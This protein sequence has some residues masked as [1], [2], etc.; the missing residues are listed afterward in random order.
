[1]PAIE[2]RL[3]SVAVSLF[4]PNVV[5][6]IIKPSIASIGQ[7]ARSLVV[8]LGFV[9][10]LFAG[11]SA[12]SAYVDGVVKAHDQ[13]PLRHPLRQYL[14]ALLL[15]IVLL[16]IVIAVAPLVVLSSREVARS[17]P[18]GL[19]HF[20]RFGNYPVLALAL[21]LAVTTLYRA[22]LPRPLP[23]HRLIWGSALATGLFLIATCALRGYLAWKTSSGTNYG[24]L[25]TPIALMLYAFFAGFDIMLGAEF[26][27]A[28]QEN[29]PVPPARTRPFRK[30]L[31]AH[32]DAD[33]SGLADNG[34]ATAPVRGR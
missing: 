6:E 33:N 23:W 27:A 15:Y 4:S 16:V 11:S 18:D 32:A 19:N 24:V 17:L 25:G 14:Y 7:G 29:W 9:T 31:K 28:I 13:N 21:I 10:A 26:N 22:A 20:L 2:E 3:V 12:I 1:L 34:G 8:S 5:N 30:W